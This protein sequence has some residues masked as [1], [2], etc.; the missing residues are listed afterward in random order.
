MQNAKKMVYLAVLVD[1]AL[2]SHDDTPSHNLLGNAQYFLYLSTLFICFILDIK[3]A[4][5]FNI[6][7]NGIMKNP[8]RSIF[9][10]QN[11]LQSSGK[12]IGN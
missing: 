2:C 3:F 5:K 12:W 8:L 10:L 9:Y 6:D 4:F 1:S 11:N 7:D